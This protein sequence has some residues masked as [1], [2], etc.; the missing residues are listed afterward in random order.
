MKIMTS[1]DFENLFL[2]LRI[3]HIMETWHNFLT[4]V[5]CGNV[6]SHVQ[7][8]KLYW[9]ILNEWLCSVVLRSGYSIQCATLVIDWMVLLRVYNDYDFIFCEVLIGRYHWLQQWSLIGRSQ[10]PTIVWE[11]WG[12]STS[13][14]KLSIP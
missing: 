13:K 4:W 3:L 14:N 8:F 11:G 2:K 5:P 9:L 10:R 7:Q 1:I 6:Y 12:T